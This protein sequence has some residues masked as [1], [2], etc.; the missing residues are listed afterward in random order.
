MR[1][2]T[3]LISF[4]CGMMMTGL[5]GCSKTPEAPVLTQIR[6]KAAEPLQPASN[7]AGTMM[8]NGKQYSPDMVPEFKPESKLKVKVDT[9]LLQPGIT[10]T[11]GIIKF[12]RTVDG[13]KVTGNSIGLNFPAEDVEIELPGR[14]GEWDLLV[15]NTQNQLICSQR[16]N[17]VE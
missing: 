10:E 15:L 5:Y 16:I 1:F 17:V 14:P 4:L 2:P 12:Q 13:K 3:G 6:Q 9:T 7:V 8:L 11:A